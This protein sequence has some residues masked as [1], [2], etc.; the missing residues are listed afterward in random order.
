MRCLSLR[1]LASRERN[2]KNPRRPQL[3]RLEIRNLLTAA[4]GSADAADL[5]SGGLCQCPICSGA[6]LPAE[7][8]SVESASS[9]D[10]SASLVPGLP[11]LSS[12]PSAQAKLFL[13]FDG[14]FEATW[15]SRFNISTPAYDFDGVLSSFS[16]AEQSSISQIW[17][18]VAEDY[19]PFN[20]DVTTI[21][22]GT[23]ADRVVAVVAIGGSN[24][25]WYG[26]SA[27]GVAYVG[28]FY[29]SSSNVAYAF[30]NNLGNGNVKYTT[31]AVSHEAGH[32]FGLNHQAVWNGTTMVTAYN[33]GNADWA[34]IMGVG[35]YSARTTWHNG[36]TNLGPTTYQD[37]IAVLA[38]AN[39]GFG[40]K[41][42]DFG[43]SIST[44]SQLA[45]SG[46]TVSF[47]GLL[48]HHQDLD[49]WQ[50]TTAGGAA[51]FTLNA[52]TH[53][54]NL[55]SILELRDAGGNLLAIANP[56]GTF[57]ASINATLG[58]GSY[59]VIARSDGAYG[60][61]GQYTLN[62]S[63]QGLNE[64][65]PTVYPPEISV[66]VGGQNFVSGA[67]INF[68]QV[69][70]G[71]SVS[72]TI[73]V[74]NSGSGTLNLS[75]IDANSLPPGFTLVSN[76]GRLQLA[77]GESTQFVVQFGAS[78]PGDYGGSL[79][80]LSHD[81]DE[82]TYV[83]GLQGKATAGAATIDDGGIGWSRS[84]PW[85]Q[86]AGAG[87]ESDHHELNRTNSSHYAAWTFDGLA[88]GQYRIWATWTGASAN[89]AAA[90]FSALQSGATLAAWS[91]NQQVGAGGF[92]ADGAQWSELGVVPISGNQLVIR[93][94]NGGAGLLV[95]DAIR[96]EWLGSASAGSLAMSESGP[97]PQAA[98]IATS[99]AWDSA[100]KGS[101]ASESDVQ[102]RDEPVNLPAQA[103]FGRNDF[104]SEQEHELDV[105][106]LPE[107]EPSD[108]VDDFWQTCDEQSVE[109]LLL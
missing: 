43:N 70:I 72:R 106:P 64:N 26:S 62:G 103:H 92:A 38:G 46:S 91:V 47:A 37:N 99:P 29:N 59:Y 12:N 19:A 80:L 21:D 9:S 95:A 57:N 15:G 65:P 41:A 45:A 94:T 48:G 18:R 86:V 93:L 61:M 102:R 11:L 84:G 76:L 75:P 20:I 104:V 52:A 82:G 108:S 13:D 78:T 67:T 81:A 8:S 58:S 30:E 6:G 22:P 32:L 96:I 100:V 79:R 71:G 63:V 101:S 36:P 87:F 68:G 39:N 73:T 44:A 49:V 31:E 54:P 69:L 66:Q 109:E 50:F 89:T 24:T 90:R 42:D 105:Y 23:V 97:T 55:D 5:L 60:N 83:F 53:S 7:S 98:A 107:D 2:L 1:A 4:S 34:P 40:L 28:G 33:Q 74:A 88:A 51:S 16:A 27:G 3:E 35:Y 85:K 77:A 10:P 14:R 56:T 25:D 17:A